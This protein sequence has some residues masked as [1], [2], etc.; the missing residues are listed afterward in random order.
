V[1]TVADSG[2]W[3]PHSAKALP[4]PWPW[5]IAPL[6]VETPTVYFKFPVD[7]PI[8]HKERAQLMDHREDWSKSLVE[9]S[10]SWD[11]GEA[12][13]LRLLVEFLMEAFPG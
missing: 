13:P 12:P 5:S 9:P 2:V 11:K 4:Y 10:W 6:W 7:R 8:P 3:R 1:T